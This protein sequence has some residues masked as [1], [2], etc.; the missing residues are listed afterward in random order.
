M[1]TSIGNRI[2]SVTLQQTYKSM[3]KTIIA[4]LALAGMAGADTV[5]FDFDAADLT[6]TGLTSEKLSDLD[7]GI[8]AIISTTDTLVAG[9]WSN[10]PTNNTIV[11]PTVGSAEYD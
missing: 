3:K 7:S 6:A 8:D 9:D 4:L 2:V 5:L 11:S 10:A 1:N